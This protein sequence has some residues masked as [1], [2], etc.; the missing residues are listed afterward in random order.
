MPEPLLGLRA[1]QLPEPDLSSLGGLSEEDIAFLGELNALAGEM[2]LSPELIQQIAVISR[3]SGKSPQAVWSAILSSEQGLASASQI[4]ELLFADE[5]GGA[6]GGSS[7]ASMLA[8]NASMMNAQENMRQG[9]YDRVQDRLRLLQA[10]DQLLD[11]RRE[12]AM[13]ALIQAAPLM[14]APGTEFAPGF[15]PGGPAMRLSN[16]IG[17]G[18]QPQPMPTAE[19]PLGDYLAEERSVTPEM[20]NRDLLALTGGS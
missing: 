6:G 17:A 11:A 2:G 9:A 19:L 3:Q 18:L 16:M 1:P 5:A 12:N 20:I 13:S 15:E 8:A 14:V 10:T 7:A 4:G